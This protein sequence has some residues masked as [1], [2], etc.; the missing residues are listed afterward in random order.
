M[1]GPGLPCTPPVCCRQDVRAGAVSPSAA[2]RG[3]ARGHVAPDLPSAPGARRNACCRPADL[4]ARR[5]GSL[6]DLLA[7]CRQVVQLYRLHQLRALRAAENTLVVPLRIDARRSNRGESG[8]G[9][10]SRPGYSYWSASS[11]GD[12]EAL[13]APGR[14]PD[15]GDPRARTRPPYRR[16]SGSIACSVE[17]AIV[18]P[19]DRFPGARPDACEGVQRIV[20]RG[21]SAPEMVVDQRSDQGRK[22]DP[23]AARLGMQAPIVCLLEQDLGAVPAG[24]L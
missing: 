9:S 3:N 18:L 8:S 14:D 23:L 15:P 21:A 16:E 22:T 17:M 20:R 11:G 4:A 13:A 5:G 1:G 12:P 10:R 7:T 2:G 19:A 24:L 6:G